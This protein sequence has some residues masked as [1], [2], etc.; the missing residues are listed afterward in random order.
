[1]IA[2][3]PRGLAPQEV[4]ASRERHGDNVITPPKDASAWLLLLDKFRDPIIRILLLAA[5]L[6]LVIGFIHRDFTESIGI[7]CAI[8]LA[9]CVGFWWSTS[10]AARR[11]RPTAS[12]S[13]PCR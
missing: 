7:I 3:N 10:R 11:F 2:Y 4:A 5:V 6:S 9:T 8:I 13:K 1:M 12:W